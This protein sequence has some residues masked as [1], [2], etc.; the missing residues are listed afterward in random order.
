MFPKNKIN[1]LYR[2]LCLICYVGVILV[3][4]NIRT[5]VVLYVAFIVFAL[6]ERSFRNIELII[7]T[8]LTL[9]ISTL[10][11]SNIFFKILLLIDYAL[12]FLDAS[13]YNIEEE[14]TISE[15]DY[16]RFKNNKKKKKGSNNILALYLTLHLVILFVAIMVG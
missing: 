4:N 13:Y 5:L 10:I 8:G 1:I 15:N 16:I 3:I 11:D 2:I 14:A 12:Y 9:W 7:I 6:N